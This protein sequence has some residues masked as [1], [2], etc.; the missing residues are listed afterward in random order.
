M[1][2]SPPDSR[3]PA[4]LEVSALIRLAEAGGGF[5][6]VLAKG[7]RDAGTI[8]LVTMENGRNAQF[9]ERMPQL[10]S[11]RAWTLTRTEDIDNKANFSDY[12]ARRQRQD[13]DLWIVEVDIADAA[14][15]VEMLPC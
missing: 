14:R 12:L 7:E 15:F 3:M 13:S 10:D 2:D 9:Y 6:T 5:A 8:A 4:H 1:A 11:S